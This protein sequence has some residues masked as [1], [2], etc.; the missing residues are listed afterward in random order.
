VTARSAR[1]RSRLSPKPKRQAEAAGWTACAALI[2]HGVAARAAALGAHGAATVWVVDDEKLAHYSPEGYAAALQAVVDRC[3]PEVLFMAG[4][5]VGA[6]SPAGSPPASAS[7]AWPTARTCRSRAARSSRCG[8]LLRQGARHREGG[9]KKPVVATLRPNVF[10][11]TPGDGVAAVETVALPAVDIRAVVRELLAKG[12]DELDV[13]EADVIVSGGRGI[14]GPE[15]FALIREL[16]QA[17]GGAVGASRAVVDAGWIDH[18]TRSA[19]P[20]R[21]CRRRSTSPAASP[22]PSSTSPGCR[23]RS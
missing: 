9:A 2:G 23:R 3:R 17:L 8:R 11:A 18:A 5:I 21:W 12:G 14:K 15:H 19:R 6:T 20:A 1:H 7:A 10:P 13:A 4:T 16:A 22:A